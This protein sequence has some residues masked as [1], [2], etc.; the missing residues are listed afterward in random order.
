MADTFSQLLER[1][2]GRDQVRITDQLKT[3]APR[4]ADIL[5]ENAAL[6]RLAQYL[7][8]TPEALLQELVDTAVELCGAESAGV[9]LL[10][11]QPDGTTLFRWVAMA[12]RYRDFVGG[13]TPLDLSPC[14]DTM[15]AGSA[16]LYD[17]PARYYTCL[18]PADPVL[19]EGLVVPLPGAG[20]QKSRGTIW[21]ALH[22]RTRAFD[23][24]HVRL[25]T[26]IASFT[27]NALHTQGLLA[28]AVARLEDVEK[29]NAAARAL[30]EMR[31]QF[32]GI[33]GHDLRNPLA[34]IVNG[35]QLLQGNL[36]PERLA[37]IARIISSSAARMGELIDNLLDF[38]RSRL[39]NGITVRRQ[40]TGA[41]ETTL[42]HVV[43]ELHSAHPDRVIVRQF[44]FSAPANVDAARIGQ[45]VSNLLGNALTHGDHAK[46]VHVHG[47]SSAELLVIS[48]SNGGKAIPADVQ[49]R[50][51]KP[52][53][54][55]NSEGHSV[56]HAEGLGLGL[57][58][59]CEI[60]RAHGGRLSVTSTD[61]ET[62]FRFVMPHAQVS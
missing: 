61:D 50:L 30:G 58:I 47:K 10:E 53:E 22:D 45:M 3:R 24:E 1:P 26:S 12:G 20:G 48:V 43:A 25:M 6:H 14:G 5:A 27:A 51:F 52:F 55:G 46:P 21:I 36:P 62:V 17:L 37:P 56:G 39:G 9:S 54:R 7:T 23:L 42:N 35:A 38:T 18:L 15:R 33:L 28:T 34:A 2:A 60:A 59:S 29:A 44:D 31:E 11:D 13:W 41:L 16:Q 40:P 8:Q 49:A 4:A 19:V 57:Y 32:M